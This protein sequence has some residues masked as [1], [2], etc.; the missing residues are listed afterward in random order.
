M[1]LPELKSRPNVA[2]TR[3]GSD[4]NSRNKAK[5]FLS[6][7]KRNW[8]KWLVYKLQLKFLLN[9][10]NQK[11]WQLTMHCH[12]SPPDALPTCRTKSSYTPLAAVSDRLC[13]PEY[14]STVHN[15]FSGKSSVF[16]GGLKVNR[17][18]RTAPWHAK[19]QKVLIP[20]INVLHVAN[21]IVRT[22]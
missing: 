15:T 14:Q 6:V 3:P 7:H 2:K 8:D 10:N 12:L 17:S 16:H 20:L 4:M 18:Y 11:R 19:I 5:D 22:M 21:Y 13:R 9:L 1:K